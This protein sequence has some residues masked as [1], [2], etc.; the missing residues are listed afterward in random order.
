MANRGMLP[1]TLAYY[2]GHSDERVTNKFYKKNTRD[3]LK[4]GERIIR[5]SFGSP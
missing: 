1:K 4:A 3:G 2:M 5:G